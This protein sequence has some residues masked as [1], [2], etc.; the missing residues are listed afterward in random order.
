[1]LIA[2]VQVLMDRHHIVTLIVEQAGRRDA[3]ST[4]P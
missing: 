1:M 2:S 3:A 4:M